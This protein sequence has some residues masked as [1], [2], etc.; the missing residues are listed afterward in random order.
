LL[1][2]EDAWEGTE[3]AGEVL[4]AAW[5]AEDAGALLAGLVELPPQAARPNTRTR[6]I[7]IAKIFFVHM[8]ISLSFPLWVVFPNGGV[9]GFSIGGIFERVNTISVM[10]IIFI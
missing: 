9:A 1:L 2:W 5:L 7:K 4:G 6:V 8:C 3:D 10:L